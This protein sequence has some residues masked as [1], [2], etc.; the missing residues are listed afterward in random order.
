MTRSVFK[1]LEAGE[2]VRRRAAPSPLIGVPGG[3][4]GE[5]RRGQMAPGVEAAAGSSPERK[6][7]PGDTAARPAARGGR[8]VS[9]DQ[10]G[11]RWG[12]CPRPRERPSRHRHPSEAARG[13][14]RL[15]WMQSVGRKEEDRDSGRWKPGSGAALGPPHPL[16]CLCTRLAE[17]LGRPQ[18]APPGA[19]GELGR[20][21]LG[22]AGCEQETSLD[23]RSRG[24]F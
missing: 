2:S 8:G 15:S 10:Q 12:R 14:A 9:E 4:K 21:H 13:A 17:P 7:W 23:L 11:R 5:F 19:L 1:E 6:K 20:E 3:A 24:P 16:G 18:P 22:N